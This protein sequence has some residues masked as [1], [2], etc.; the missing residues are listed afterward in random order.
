MELDS[1]TMDL[2]HKADLTRVMARADEI[3]AVTYELCV[4]Y[5]SGNRERIREVEKWAI[6][7]Y[8]LD[9]EHLRTAKDRAAFMAPQYE[10]AAARWKGVKA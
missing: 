5:A 7:K 1:T 9:H 4:A 3:R 6:E 2:L 10:E 8:R